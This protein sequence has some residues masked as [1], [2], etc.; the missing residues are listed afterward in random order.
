MSPGITRSAGLA[1]ERLVVDEAGARRTGRRGR[2]A[3]GRSTRSSSASVAPS[4]TETYSTSASGSVGEDVS[5]IRIRS[6]SR[7]SLA[8]L[9]A[10]RCAASSARCRTGA[11]ARSAGVRWTLRDESARPSGSRTVGQAMTSVGQREVERH[12]AD[13]HDLLGVLLAEVGVLGADEP[14][15]D[16]DD[17]R[18]AVEVPGPRGA[19]ERPGDRTRRGPSCRSRGRR[20]PRPAAPRRG[21]RPRPRRSRGRAPRSAGTS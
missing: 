21:R 16:R 11:A 7:G 19:L 8:G 3:P 5:S 6:A 15:Q 12:P 1:A 2:A 10:S 9:P 17:R 4:A 20:P 14:E 18:H 13:D